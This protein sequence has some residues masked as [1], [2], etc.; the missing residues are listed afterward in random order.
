MSKFEMS[1]LVL[2]FVGQF[3]FFMRFFIQWICTEKY[4]KS[5]IPV[6]FWYFSLIG[7]F[8]LLI[9]AVLRKDIV[10]TVGQAGGSV[11]YMRNLYFIHKEKNAKK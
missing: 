5:V 7:G 8:L 1:L 2:G 3:F 6:A 9:Y 11:I 10:F 4:K